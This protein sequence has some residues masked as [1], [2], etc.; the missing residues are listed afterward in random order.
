MRKFDYDE[1]LIFGAIF[2]APY[3]VLG[4][5]VFWAMFFKE[6]FPRVL[7]YGIGG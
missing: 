5:L 6:S 4:V 2:L 1:D 3:A 7:I